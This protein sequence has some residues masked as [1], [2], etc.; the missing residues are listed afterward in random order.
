MFQNKKRFFFILLIIVLIKVN[1]GLTNQTAN[2]I[3]IIKKN[4]KNESFEP[5]TDAILKSSDPNEIMK[6]LCFYDNEGNED[7]RDLAY[8]YM[9]RLIKLHPQKEIKREVAGRLVQAVIHPERNNSRNPYNWLSTSFVEED[10]T[11]ESKNFI[12]K[13]IDDANVARR[14]IIICGVANLK[15]Q[16]PKLEKLLINEMEYKKKE[17]EENPDFPYSFGL[18]SSNGWSARLARARM[19]VKEDIKR[20]I[21]VVEAEKDI[22][23]KLTNLLPQIG[24]IRQPEAIE[25]LR[26][27]LESNQMLSGGKDT[28]GTNVGLNTMNILS[29]CLS[30]FP[31][32]KKETY[33]SFS[34]E[35]LD[36]CRIWMAQQ[37]EWK[38]IR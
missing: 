13:Y 17:M 29:Q 36:Q 27:Y 30:N 25:Y 33:S 3:S 12:R 34:M 15:D 9:M 31:F 4:I 6:L 23:R 5:A 7:E 20:C 10:F 14:M 37:K 35:E 38:I 18:Y 16:I 22:R 2:T 26:K 32:K 28:I 19:G 21:E 24:Y 8:R 1:S 11:E